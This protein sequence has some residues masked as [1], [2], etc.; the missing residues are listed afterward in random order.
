MST[1]DY[2]A[3][4]RREIRPFVPAEARS[5]LDIGCGEGVFGAGLKGE[6][7]DVEVWGVE[8]DPAAAAHAVRALDRVIIGL[9]PAVLA[10]LAGRRFDCVVMND[11]IE[12]V[13]EPEELLVAV[14]AHVAPGG[15]LV[16]SI[17]NIRHYTAVVDLALRGR[18]DYTDEGIL[19]RTHLRFF[20]RSSM[21]D[22]LVRCGYRVTGVTGIN[23]TGAKAFR[24]FDMLTMG[25][26]RDMGH[27]QFACVAEPKEGTSS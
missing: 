19:D 6:R 5:V 22:L 10:E 18:W 11:I 15:C 23:R 25:R 1:R 17:P 8:A 2:H 4:P 9:A 21:T 24:L 27:L 13:V 16:A 12:H 14:R 3:R 20:T 7:G 26:F